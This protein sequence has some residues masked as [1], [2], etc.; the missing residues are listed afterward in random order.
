MKCNGFQTLM[1]PDGKN[2]NQ[3]ASTIEGFIS[4]YKRK[5]SGKPLFAII[6]QNS[7]NDYNKFKGIFTKHSVMSQVILKMTARKMNLS[8]ASNIMK[9]INSKVGGESV[10]MKFPEVMKKERFMVIG[11]DVCHA[12]KKSVVGFCA[13]INGAY[14]KYYN[15]IIIQPKFQ[16]IVLKDLNTCLLNAMDAFQKENQGQLPSKILIY[17]DGVGENMR[18]LIEKSEVSQFKMAL[19]DLYNKVT[20]V[21]PITMVVVN[22]RINQRMFVQDRNGNVCNPP[23]GS[24]IDTGLVEHQSGANCFDFFLVPQQT[25]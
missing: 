14:T 21:P 11:I 12:G 23:P 10:R 4:D 5:G 16:E 6:I 18:D 13:T 25:T 17:R 24:I 1:L 7:R 3:V 9:Q 22:K 2:F 8:V 15:D 19:K 20:G